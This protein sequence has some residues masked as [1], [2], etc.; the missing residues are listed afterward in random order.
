MRERGMP[1][2]IPIYGPRG[3]SRHPEADM[4]EPLTLTPDD[5]N[6]LAAMLPVSFR[7]TSNALVS[8]MIP[9]VET[10]EKIAA[11]IE[12][13]IRA[14]LSAQADELRRLRSALLTIKFGKTP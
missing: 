2:A 8:E 14:T 7:F 5:K 11:W 4:S 9:T 1:G 13:K 10:V 12:G 3:H 6:M